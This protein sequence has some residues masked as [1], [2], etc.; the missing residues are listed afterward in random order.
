MDVNTTHLEESTQSRAGLPKNGVENRILVKNAC[1]DVYRVDDV[2]TAYTQCRTGNRSKSGGKHKCKLCRLHNR[3]FL[4]HPVMCVSS[5]WICSGDISVSRGEGSFSLSGPLG[6]RWG[7]FE[8]G[9]VTAGLIS[10]PALLDCKSQLVSSSSS[11]ESSSTSPLATQWTRS[12][13]P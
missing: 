6:D 7:V 4:N 3:V 5:F 2:T 8:M 9:D 12:D 1:S 10:L 11:V 13:A